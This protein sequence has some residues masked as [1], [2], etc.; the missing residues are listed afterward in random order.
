MVRAKQKKNNTC[1]RRMNKIWK[2]NIVFYFYCNDM[3]ILSVRLRL[4]LKFSR[5]TCDGVRNRLS[6]FTV[7]DIKPVN[8]V[9]DFHYIPLPSAC[10]GFIFHGER[11]CWIFVVN[12]K[13]SDN[14][15]IKVWTQPMR[16]ITSFFSSNIKRL[17]YWV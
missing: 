17:L 14:I 6:T 16:L 10:V 3:S 9:S 7:H 5:Y 15:G 13:I 12:S 4:Q 2:S 11:D 8:T 1:Q